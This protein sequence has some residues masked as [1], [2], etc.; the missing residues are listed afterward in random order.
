M[1]WGLGF[2]LV[3]LPFVIA[4]IGAR[5]GRGGEVTA[6]DS[7]VRLRDVARTTARWRV[8]G[9]AVGVVMA[10]WVADMD[11]LGRGLMLA[12]PVFG[13]SVLLG[14]VVGELRVCAPSG[15]VRTAQFEVRRVRDYLPRLLTPFVAAALAILV[16]LLAFT[17]IVASPDDL[18]RAGRSLTRTCPAVGDGSLG[19]TAG[20]GPWP[21]SFYALPL[22]AAV[23]GG[24][25]AAGVALIRLARR[26]RQGEDHA[27][28][29]RLRV[30]AAAAVVAA[31]GVVIGI[32]L[33]GVS[34][35]A[36]AALGNLQGTLPCATPAAWRLLI[37][38][39]VSLAPIALVLTGRCL[40][41]LARPAHRRAPSPRTVTGAAR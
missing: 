23:L 27:R 2:V 12:A 19:S 4:L 18:G 16:G 21:G 30:H 40:A 37:P 8:A 36:A 11:V 35:V 38:V 3:V 7:A 24:L 28:D 22:A 25:L 1:A 6:V 13:L 32:P 39:L 17:T 29:E 41:V 5:L 15:P 14:V 26:P 20:V 31:V 10:W 33:A 34:A 9:L